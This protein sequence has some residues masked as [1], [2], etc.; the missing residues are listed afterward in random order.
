M[1]EEGNNAMDMIHQ[2]ATGGLWFGLYL[3]V[4]FLMFVGGDS[5]MIL[6]LL[7]LVMLFCAP[8]MVLRMLRALYLG[9]QERYDFFRLWSMSVLIFAFASLICAF[10]TFVWIQFVQPGFLYDKVQE[11]VNVYRTVPE[12][13]TSEM[14]S[15]MQRAIDNGELPTPIQF[16][17]QMGWSTVMIGS[18]ISMPMAYI[19]R[20]G[21]KRK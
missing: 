9:D 19:A 13:Q 3:S 15:V 8:V 14:V 17:V 6:S 2:A 20:L 21:G 7:A 4:L 1:K 11:A 18:L 10:V 12:L 5:S 16:V